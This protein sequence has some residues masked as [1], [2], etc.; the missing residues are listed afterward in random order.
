M[1]ARLRIQAPLADLDGLHPCDDDMLAL[2]E[3]K[4][5]GSGEI[6]WSPALRLGA[7]YF[8]ADDFYE[9]MVARLVTEG[10]DWIDVGCGRDIFPSNYALAEQLAGRVDH[11]L[12]IDPDDNIQQ[13]DLLTDRHQGFIEDCPTER[14]FDV[15]SLRMVAE[16][17]A[18]ADRAVA[19]LA[20][21]S[22]PGAY[23]IIYTPWKYSPISLA[24]TA[25]PFRFHNTLKRLIWD[26][27]P[28][29]TFPTEYKM[30]TRKDLLALFSGHGFDEAYFSRVDDCSVFTKFRLLNRLEIGVRNAFLALRIP[31]P[32]HCLLACY[33]RQAG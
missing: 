31:Y 14:Q 1:N 4:Y 10:S 29:D 32:E 6:G 11:L 28:E 25:V 13:N 7:G 18:E 20:E 9:Y 26:T 8:A 33:R 22:K 16:H 30:N 15:I 2:F 3:Q 17:I 23:V 21:L 27:E 19:R 24:A 12:G 5:G